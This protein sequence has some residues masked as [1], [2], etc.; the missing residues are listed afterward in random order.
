MHTVCSQPGAKPGKVVNGPADAVQPIGQDFVDLPG[1]R[2]SEQLLKCR[3]VDVLAGKPFIRIDLAAFK[4]ACSQRI[5]ANLCLL[6]DR[7]TVRPLNGLTGVYGDYPASLPSGHRIRSGLLRPG[8]R[9]R[10]V[11]SLA[12]AYDLCLQFP[13]GQFCLTGYGYGQYVCLL[14]AVWGNCAVWDGSPKC[15]NITVFFERLEYAD[16]NKAV[17]HM[18]SRQ[19]MEGKPGC[20]EKRGEAA[21]TPLA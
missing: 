15:D 19:E 16:T 8:L 9:K 18:K 4:L 17:L 7:D 6:F 10:A 11:K 3:T 1:F 14:S 13:G 5:A 20:G 12:D 2:I 21:G